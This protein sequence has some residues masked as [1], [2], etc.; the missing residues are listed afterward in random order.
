MYVPPI[1]IITTVIRN[2]MSI[3][4]KDLDRDRL[5]EELWNR[6]KPALFYTS[7]G[8]PA[9]VFNL[10]KYKREISED[11]YIDYFCGRLIKTN[12]SGDI[13]DP[14]LYDRDNGEGAFQSVVDKLKNKN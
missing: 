5:L 14:Y 4:I 12:L 13:V 7:T 10:E 6:S 9:P 2:N 11:G 3:N 1:I 8:L